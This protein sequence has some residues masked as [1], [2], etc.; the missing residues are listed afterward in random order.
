[1]HVIKKK[2][3]KGLER[4]HTR[5]TVGYYFRTLLFTVVR[6]LWRFNLG[7]LIFVSEQNV[8]NDS[9]KFEKKEVLSGLR[10]QVDHKSS[11]RRFRALAELFDL[12]FFF[13]GGVF[14]FVIFRGWTC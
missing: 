7:F 1:M 9:N 11:A 10:V 5:A 12:D 6:D 13:W 4:V 8:S 14:R 2:K 3:K